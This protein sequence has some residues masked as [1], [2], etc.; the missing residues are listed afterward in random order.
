MSTT[1]RKSQSHTDAASI[2]S[3]LAKKLKQDR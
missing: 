2:L 1:W 3:H